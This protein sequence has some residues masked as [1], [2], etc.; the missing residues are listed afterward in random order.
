MFKARANQ[1]ITCETGHEVGRFRND[2]PSD[3]HIKA[4]D[5]DLP[6]SDS[7]GAVETPDK[8][9]TGH[10]CAKMQGQGDLLPR[11]G[12]SGSHRKRVDSL[13]TL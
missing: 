11:R 2:V 13:E 7:G 5:L 9:A 4:E 8:V 6:F 10:T 1:P 3:R 12:V